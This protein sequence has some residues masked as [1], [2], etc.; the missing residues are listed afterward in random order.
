[1]SED[2]KSEILYTVYNNVEN[3]DAC[4]RP[5][6]MEITLDKSVQVRILLVSFR[7]RSQARI[8]MCGHVITTKFSANKFRSNPSSKCECYSYRIDHILCTYMYLCFSSVITDPAHFSAPV[9]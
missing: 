5:Y 8:T 3:Q 6:T 2:V 4:A 1:M 9:V 7:I